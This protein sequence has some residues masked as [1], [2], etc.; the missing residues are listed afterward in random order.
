[1]SCS[2][3]ERKGYN[4][5]P[6]TPCITVHG[7][8]VQAHVLLLEP[9][10]LGL[11]LVSFFFQLVSRSGAHRLVRPLRRLLLFFHF[12]LKRLVFLFQLG[13]FLDQRFIPSSP[14]SDETRQQKD[15]L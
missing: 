7:V 3:K 14:Q 2:A 1:V 11:Q 5:H 10:D 8:V 4:K 15:L 12:F 9:L 6:D 13:D